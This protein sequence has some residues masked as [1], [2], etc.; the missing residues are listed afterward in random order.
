MLLASADSWR[1]PAWRCMAGTAAAQWQPSHC[2]PH[3][4]NVGMPQA[5][6]QAALLQES[7]WEHGNGMFSGS[8]AVKGSGWPSGCTPAGQRA[9]RRNGAGQQQRQWYACNGQRAGAEMRSGLQRLPWI[10]T[11][12][13]GQL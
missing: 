3:L 1:P 8:M 5:G 7:V 4:H 11:E 6:H 9:G 10:M 2:F 12:L 13:P